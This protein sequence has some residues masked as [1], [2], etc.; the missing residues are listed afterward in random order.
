MDRDVPAAIGALRGKLI[1]SCQA[2]AGDPFRDPETM[3]RF[4]RAA[5]DNGAAG[6]RA[7]GA[8]DI[9]A[10]RRMVDAPIIGIEKVV[11]ADGE[12]L[13]TPT[14][15]AARTI[16][17]A[18]ATFV[19]LDCTT[20]GQRYGA[21]ERLARVR[22]ELGVPVL[23]DI[24][25]VE[26]ALAA[27]EAGADLVLSTLR[28]Y[29]RE[30]KQVIEFDAAFI[31]ELAG[32]LDVPVIAEG[33]I[34]TPSQAREALAAG[35]FAVV[36]GTA[37]T[38]PGVLTKRFVEALGH[39][40]R[41]GAR[42][43]AA[44][45]DLGGTN[46]KSGVVSP[47]GELMCRASAPT[48]VGGGRDALL[49]HLKKVAA[50]CLERAATEGVAIGALGVATAGWVDPFSG[51]VVFATENLPG[52]TGTPIADELGAATGLPVAVEN[53]ANAL[54]VAEKRFGLAKQAR[55]FVCITLGTGVGGGCY[56]NG[57]L[58]RG[59]NFFGNA[60][61]HIPIEMDG[62]PC[63]CGRK[64]C[65]EV[66]ANA[67]ALLKYAQAG[68]FTSTEAVIVAANSGD[69]AAEAAL[70]TYSRYLAGGCAVLVQLLDP[71]LIVLSGGL[72]EK[73]PLLPRLLEEELR[74][75]VMVWEL[76]GLKIQVS[77]LGYHG[78]VY[79]AAAVALAKTG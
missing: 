50:G 38:R 3:A 74:T 9:A 56:V 59:V 73:N 63:N 75:R 51:R 46:T 77:A 13:I 79:G 71:E 76:R 6:I 30:T 14:F 15:Q 11:A 57:E 28:G 65:L 7:N 22:R 43:C 69:A 62:A 29:T 44:A 17:E 1:V 53:D 8:A 39:G 42:T 70:R 54:A 25:T 58:N 23:A 31:R 35:A 27:A 52:W 61:G 4:A 67:A 18:G 68:G 34:D 16:V 55:N 48:P 19:A 33:R 64:G 10:I 41:P 5:V 12:I 20:R 66:Y 2:N 37:I 21:F 60:L 24:A 78:G 32:R 40:E 36:V 47:D 72:A 45:I 26:E 49:G